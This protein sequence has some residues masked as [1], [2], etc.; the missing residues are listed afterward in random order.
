VSKHKQAN[1]NKKEK[2]ATSKNK[3]PQMILKTKGENAP[4][5]LVE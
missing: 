1:K 3:Q 5:I 2:H 4:V